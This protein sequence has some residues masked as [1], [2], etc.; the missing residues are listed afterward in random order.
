MTVVVMASLVVPLSAPVRAQAPPAAVVSL[1]SQ[2]TWW[3]P[4]QPFIVELGVQT[5]GAD[6]LE[7]AVSL[8]RKVPNRTE[9]ART[10]EGRTTG[11]AIEEIPPIPLADLA[12][13][14]EGDR[15]LSFTP[16][17]RAPGVYPV[18]IEVRAI[19][20]TGS[21]GS[22]RL[23][24]T[25]TL[26][27]HLVHVPVDLPG[28]KLAVALVIPAHARPA[29]QPD[30]S[31]AIDDARAEKLAELAATVEA[32]PD[33]G[34][35]VAPTP[36]TA[37]A[38]AESPREQDRTTLAT[39]SRSLGQ[40][41]L[42]GGH[43]VPTNLMAF[44]QAGLIEE[45]SGQLTRGTDTLR[46][47]FE[48][49]PTTSSRLIDERLS[50]EALSVLQ[51]DQQVRRLI[52]PE[53][54]LEV[55]DRRT[56]LTNPFELQG[57]RDRVP[58]AVVD[59]ALAGHFDGGDDVLAAHRLLADLAVIY[60]D[61][62]TAD[63]RGVVVSPPRSWD[64]SGLFLKTLLDAMTSSPI[65]EGITVDRFFDTVA[66]ATTGTGSRAIPLLR[67]FAPPAPAGPSLPGATL[68]QMRRRIDAFASAV[69]PFNPVIDRLDRT[70]LVAQ[71]ADLRVRDRLKYLE[72]VSDQ[73]GGE[74]SKIAM[75]QNRS[76]TLTARDGEIPIT[77][78]STLG[79]PVRAILRVNS[80]T[81]EF[82]DG[83]SRNLYLARRNTT[84]QFTV[85]AQ[86]SG[87][88]PL[89]V[90]LESPEGLVM[91]ESLFTVRST[92]ISGV[93]TALSIGAGFFLLVWW[94]N[95]LRGRRSRRL[96]PAAADA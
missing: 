8:F 74:I 34:L 4:E 10:A 5:A 12:V 14:D 49:E 87:S 2:T 3:V 55:I 19:N 59:G 44:L 73:I 47:L 26:V 30:G 48:R 13:D 51:A 84:A 37:E 28:E 42:L 46:T 92:A 58:A 29:V 68:G 71:S 1:R 43:Y 93:G 40:R 90:R 52:I 56:T 11:R 95:H 70:L 65:L 79:Y 86:S 54:L 82:P 9:F 24:Q 81:L 45:A 72:G 15:I 22:A 83:A 89:R 39:L 85:Q 78:T 32:H 6:D 36:E 63:K 75:P 67:S 17:A 80:D 25:G 61:D 76:I 27:T 88:F 77:I 21:G 35:T 57:R 50:D 20:T 66:M 41:Q 33:V 94:G 18:R 64:P 16:V 60:N 96:V 91:A 31:V 23:R 53:S 7:V 69:E 38:L 62:P